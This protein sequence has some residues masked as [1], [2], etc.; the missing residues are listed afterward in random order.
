MQQKTFQPCRLTRRSLLVR[1]G[2][3][4]LV[5]P[6]LSRGP[7][8]SAK[9][10]TILGCAVGGTCA[11]TA[12][13]GESIPSWTAPTYGATAATSSAQLAYVPEGMVFVPAGTYVM[14]AANSP[15]YT[16]S[17]SGSV[18]SGNGDNRHSVTLS[19]FC[20]SKYLITN[21]QYKAFCDE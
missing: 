6:I 12:A 11:T 14:G 16:V 20:I 10:Q 3:G 2:L 4:A 15:V 7:R 17:A 21:A 13:N 19:D 5:L 1:F 9:A 8:F 18:N